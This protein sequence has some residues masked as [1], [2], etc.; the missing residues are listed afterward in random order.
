MDRYEGAK[1]LIHSQSTVEQKF[2]RKEKGLLH[3]DNKIQIIKAERQDK[4]ISLNQTEMISLKQKTMQ[5]RKKICINKK[6]R[7]VWTTQEDELLKCSIQQYGSN[8]VQ[9]AAQMVNR[10]PSQCTQRWKRIKPQSLKKR[11]PFSEEEDQLILQLV[12]K[13][14]Q[15]WGK[16]A[17]Q[18]PDR[19]NKQIRERYI[20]KLNPQNKFEP[21]SEKEDQII[22]QAYQEMGSK[23]TKIQNLLVGRPEN[24]IKNRFYSYLRQKF[25]K[26]KNPYY[27]IPSKTD[28]TSLDSKSKMEKDEQMTEEKKMKEI[29]LQKIKIEQS[30]QR[31]ND[32]K[33]MQTQLPLEPYPY[34]Q[35]PQPQFL[36]NFSYPQYYMYQTPNAIVYTPFQQGPIN[37]QNNLFQNQ[38][39]MVQQ[40]SNQFQ[41]LSN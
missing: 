7:K 4:R 11:K 2:E 8:W 21:F 41:Y 28:I 17:Q 1:S 30:N 36:G 32:I 26:I 27:S 33:V 24:M 5:K 37:Y 23:W 31:N 19:T 18:L 13:Y 12:K 34:S 22:L 20:N 35:I 39:Y 29:E 9:I 6:I 25:L 14:K 10:N 3:K 38:I 40:E 15:N 16:I